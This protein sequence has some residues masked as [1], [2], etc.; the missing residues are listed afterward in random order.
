M[1]KK[2][3]YAAS[4]LALTSGA[5]FAEEPTMT[6][7]MKERA[8]TTAMPSA[9]VNRWLASDVYKGAVYDTAENKIGTIEDLILDGSGNV[10]TAVIGVGG[11]LGMG[12]KDVSVPFKELKVSS[13]E[14]K[15]WLVLDRSKNQLK[16]SPSFDRQAALMTTLKTGRSVAAAP[17]SLGTGQWMASEIYGADI[18]DTANNKIGAVEDLIMNSAG[19]IST[20]VI[21]VGGFLGIG[22]KEVAVPFT[23]LKVAM[24]EGKER[25][26]LDRSKD[27]LKAA[28]S[29]DKKAAIT[30]RM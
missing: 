22:E 6:H 28:P 12:E 2:L 11:F 23:D 19:N 17:S 7:P 25:F 4:I 13:R 29:F 24:H 5:L 1:M 8:A 9:A 20:A 15:N 16:A 30:E 14:G 10:T 27:Q 26:M 21:G 18:Y 3:A